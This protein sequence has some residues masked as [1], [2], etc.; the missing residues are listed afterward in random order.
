MAAVMILM[1][2]I[3]VMVTKVLDFEPN[4]FYI[5]KNALVVFY[6]KYDLACGAAGS[7]NSRYF[8]NHFQIC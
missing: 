6:P 3:L 7:Q 8:L 2:L 4:N 5:T 1:I